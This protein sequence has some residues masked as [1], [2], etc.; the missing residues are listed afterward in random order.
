MQIG[1]RQPIFR[2]LGETNVDGVP[3]LYVEGKA[4]YVRL[5]I[6]RIGWETF[7]GVDEDGGEL[8][9]VELDNCT[10]EDFEWYMGYEKK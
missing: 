5:L 9:E 3:I 8:F 4:K 7:V 6:K 10:E 1:D 2:L